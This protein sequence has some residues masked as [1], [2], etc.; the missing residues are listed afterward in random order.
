MQEPGAVICDPA[1]DERWSDC[2]SVVSG[3]PK[4]VDRLHQT[5]RSRHCSGRIER[6]HVMAMNSFIC[7]QKG[8]IPAEIGS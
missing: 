7:F 8:R 3:K 1:Q 6:T 5:L 4:L 2:L